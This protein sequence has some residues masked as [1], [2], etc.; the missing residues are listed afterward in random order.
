M[1]RYSIAREK[2]L[3]ASRRMEARYPGWQERMLATK[4]EDRTSDDL[5]RDCEYYADAQRED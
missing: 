4:A 2:R 1:A 3:S 5:S